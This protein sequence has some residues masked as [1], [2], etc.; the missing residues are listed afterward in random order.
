VNEASP[1]PPEP[2]DDDEGHRNFVN[3]IAAIFVLGLAIA[4]VWVFKS[5]D[6]HRQTE[7]CIASGRRDC[8]PL[9]DQPAER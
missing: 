2:P 5:L 7:N 4:A 1:P 9:G 8:I 6:A 3:L